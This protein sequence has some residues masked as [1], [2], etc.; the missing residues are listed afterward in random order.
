[1]QLDEELTTPSGPCC[2][3]GVR[4]PFD[5]EQ[6]NL[7]EA[8]RRL[9]DAWYDGPLLRSSLCGTHGF[10]RGGR[11]SAWSISNHRKLRKR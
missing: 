5:D 7:R 8:R 9:G 6:R 4:A 2:R 3:A 10:A 1:M 11:E